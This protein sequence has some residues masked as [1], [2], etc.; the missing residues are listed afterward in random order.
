MS[1]NVEILNYLPD[2]VSKIGDFKAI[3]IAENPEFQM[4][5]DIAER[6]KSSSLIF[7]CDEDGIKRFEKMLDIIA[8]E[9]DDLNARRY[10]I[11]ARWN[12]ALPYTLR[13]LRARLDVICG[14]GNYTITEKIGQYE[15]DIVAN[16]P[17]VGQ[18]EELERILSG[19][20][21]ANLVVVIKNEMKE[22]AET[23]IRIG[24]AMMAHE[25]CSVGKIS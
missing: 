2:F 1:R 10:R 5:F 17:F 12:D 15:L 20:V 3:A 24:V 6:A 11:L 18:I 25:V 22:R 9:A 16:L 23:A 7:Y 19:V 8:D 14:A 4:V 21:P 13:T